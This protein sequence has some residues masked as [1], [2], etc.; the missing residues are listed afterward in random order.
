[1]VFGGLRQREL[2]TG[3]SKEDNLVKWLTSILPKIPPVYVGKYRSIHTQAR[4]DI[5]I[6]NCFRRVAIANCRK[7]IL[8][9]ADF[10]CVVETSHDHPSAG[11]EISTDYR[12]GVWPSGLPGNVGQ[13]SP[14]QLHELLSRTYRQVNWMSNVANKNRLKTCFRK[15]VEK[16]VGKVL[17]VNE[18][19]TRQHD[20]LF[21]SNDLL[22]KFLR[23][24]ACP[25]FGHSSVHEKPVTDSCRVETRNKC[26]VIYRRGVRMDQTVLRKM[27]TVLVQGLLNRGSSSFRKADVNKGT[28]QN[29][30]P[31]SISETRMPGSD[32]QRTWRVAP[33]ALQFVIL[34][35][36]SLRACVT[37]YR[38]ISAR[39]YRDAKWFPAL[40]RSCSY[41]MFRPPGDMRYSMV[42]AGQYSE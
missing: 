40:R 6:P 8:R 3:E 17:S 35:D 5:R 29:R 41:A 25:G 27:C 12:L 2:R 4:I 23:Q 7:K 21:S 13:V 28:S 34:R 26:N 22:P 24:C 16:I 1:M 39:R 20:V 18:L 36:R 14:P 32:L 37:P 38:E 11:F 30:L 42:S 15:S 31:R 19:L 10:L 33:V 9:R